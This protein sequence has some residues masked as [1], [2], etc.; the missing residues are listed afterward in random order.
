[1]FNITDVLI[2]I[3]TIVIGLLLGVLIQWLINIISGEKY[4]WL[5][6]ILMKTDRWD[7]KK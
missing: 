2:V 3:A 4:K 5:W 6:N 1:M 7:G